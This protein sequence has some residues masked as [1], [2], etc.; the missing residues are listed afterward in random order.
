MSR[1]VVLASVGA[2]L[3]TVMAI[4]AS[5]TAPASGGDCVTIASFQGGCCQKLGHL[6][7]TIC[8]PGSPAQACPP[9][10]LW[11]GPATHVA[12]YQ[13]D[14]WHARDV[15]EGFGSQC[16]YQPGKC[17]TIFD[18]QPCDFEDDEETANCESNPMIGPEAE[19]CG[20]GPE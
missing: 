10:P 6:L 12:L 16:V 8:P 3:V 11:A 14:G 5:L 13:D 9:R 15:V 18:P 19:P 4:P 2:V 1:D 7:W 20:G 17:L